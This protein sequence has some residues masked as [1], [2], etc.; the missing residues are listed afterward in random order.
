MT[1]NWKKFSL[2]I[3]LQK[4]SY[5]PDFNAQIN[6]WSIIGHGV[7]RLKKIMISSFTLSLCL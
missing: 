7:I 4:R 3:Y 1:V 2:V 6:V 5:E